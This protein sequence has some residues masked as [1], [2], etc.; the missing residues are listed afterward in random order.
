MQNGTIAG[1]QSQVSES[2]FISKVFLWM[3][4][5]LAVS[6]AGCLWL[7]SQPE[8]FKAILMNRGLFFGLIIVELGLVIALSAAIGKMNST[9]AAA[10][11]FAYSFLN[12]VTLS[13]IFYV[14]TQDSLVLTF[15]VTAGMFGLFSMYGLTTRKDLTSLRGLLMVGL[16]GFLLASVV[17]FFLQSSALMWIT[18]Y[19]GIAVFLGL[20]AYDTQKLKMMY[21]SG[22]QD[23][24]SQKRLV[25]LGALALYLDFIN[26][27]LLLLRI[28]GSR[29]N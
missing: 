20:V 25:I 13:P 12:G 8:L 17:N 23:E 27:F 16:I 2:G 5:G 29:R 9:V 3:A 7:F 28:F 21:A 26:L 19:V 1:S 4:L 22:L 6:G 11:F 24:T 14:Y 15:A 18:T 10:V